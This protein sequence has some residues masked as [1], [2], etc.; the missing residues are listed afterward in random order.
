MNKKTK[1]FSAKRL[2]TDAILAAMFFALSM[3]AVEVAGVKITFVSLATVI[4]AMIY[5]PVDALIVAL[6]GA[7]MEQM[8]KFG[9]TATTALWIMPAAIRALIIGMSTVVLKKQMSLEFVLEKKKPYEYF[10]VSIVAGLVTSLANTA[11]YY[12]DAKIFG[13]Y[14]YALIFG[15]LGVRLLSG[16]IASFITAVVALPILAALRKT[17]Y[18]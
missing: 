14:S 1:G 15:V 4:C 7:F 12:V 11:V 5:G 6:L 9:F 18:I 17:N 8:L 16:I 13:Y 10:A 3:L 2:A